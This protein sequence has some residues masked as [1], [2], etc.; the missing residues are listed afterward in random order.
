V[1]YKS[2]N[3]LLMSTGEYESLQETLYLLSQSNFKDDF[4]GAVKEVEDG[5]LVSFEDVFGGAQS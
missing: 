5:E 3:A 4:S 2:E 1:Q